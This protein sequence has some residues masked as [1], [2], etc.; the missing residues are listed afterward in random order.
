MNWNYLDNSCTKFWK[1]EEKDARIFYIY[2]FFFNPE[3]NPLVKTVISIYI[4]KAKF[5]VGCYL[6]MNKLCLLK[7]HLEALAEIRFHLS[8]NFRL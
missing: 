1:N 5:F 6:F 2:W 7:L 3:K 4:V 8:L